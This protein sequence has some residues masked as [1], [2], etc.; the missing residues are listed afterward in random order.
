MIA[1]STPKARA[2]RIGVW[3]SPLFAAGLLLVFLFLLPLI[4][5]V[6]GA[7]QSTILKQQLAQKQ[8]TLE[9][10]NAQLQTLQS[11]LNA[12]TEKKNA[13][14][15]RLADLEVEVSDVRDDIEQARVDL[16][17]VRTQLEERLVNMY[18]DGTS[19]ALSYLEVLVVETDLASVL[20][21]FDMVTKMASQDQELFTEVE[22]YLER[23][24]AQKTLLEDKQAEEQGQYDELVQV[25]EQLSAKEAQVAAKNQSLQS[26]I[27]DLSAAIRRAEA[28]EAAAAAAAAA[29]LKAIADAAKPN[30]NNGGSTTPTTQPATTPTTR[31]ATPAPTGSVTPPTSAAAIK[32]QADFIYWTYLKPRKSVLTG[33]M[34]MDAW[35]KY[36]ISPAQSLTILNAESGM[37]SLKYGGRLVSQGNNFGCMRYKENP[38]WLSWPPPISHG[39]I[40]VGGR[41][42]MTFPTVA[43][44][45]EAWAR[46]IRNGL[47]RDCY[48]PLL[49]AGDWVAFADI[50]YGKGIVGEAKYIQ[51]LQWAYGMLKGT[52][53]AAGYYW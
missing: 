28:T 15:E 4:S 1:R 34:V 12:L 32:A 49:R 16:E 29:R 11:E 7:S 23:S 20:E 5:P 18:K 37:G 46:Y 50:Y 10:V 36:G 33:Q 41:T 30:P 26:Q 24:R 52:A 8:A 13:A 47:G 2:W 51:R 19:W 45:M 27:A 43:E 38:S 40:V 17:G 25:Q 48:R 44:G 9:A 14:A 3:S 21:R 42:W 31:P 53:R 22:G 39:S 6:Q 35:I